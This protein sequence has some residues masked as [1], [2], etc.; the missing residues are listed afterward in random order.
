MEQQRPYLGM[1]ARE[2]KGVLLFLL[3]SMVA[4]GIWVLLTTFIPR[5]ATPG[6]A[7][8]GKIDS[9]NALLQPDTTEQESIHPLRLHPFDPNTEDSA[10]LLDLGFDPR[11]A[12]R[13]LSYRRHKGVFRIKK[14]L[15]RLYGIDSV[16]LASIQPYNTLPD[17]LS[18]RSY[19]NRLPLYP[20][21]PTLLPSDINEVDTTILNTWPTIGIATA[22][23][24]LAYRQRLGGF[25][26]T[27]QYQEIWGLS[28]EQVQALKQYGLIPEG[29]QPSRLFLNR[30][31]ESQLRQHPYLNYKQVKLLCA[32]RAQYGPFKSWD[33]VLRAKALTPKDID[34]LRPYLSLEY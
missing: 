12:H 30:A 7:D 24:I 8:W 3:I 25:V 16:L 4:W 28:T 11:L 9:L 34:R 2:R 17:S 6:K 26:D 23:R 1:S 29:S 33:E 27:A 21:R 10:G 15:G 22:K 13:L 19:A 20:Q 14:H 31:V 5:Q 32:Y 18:R